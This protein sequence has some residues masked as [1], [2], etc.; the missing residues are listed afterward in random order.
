MNILI[1]HMFLALKAEHI[2]EMINDVFKLFLVLWTVNY[3]QI[4]VTKPENLNP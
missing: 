3:K 1:R 2:F 4:K